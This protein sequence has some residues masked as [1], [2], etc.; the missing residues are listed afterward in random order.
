[1]PLQSPK[2]IAVLV[3]IFIALA[4]FW[5]FY[6]RPQRPLSNIDTGLEIFEKKQD[7]PKT[8]E[9]TS[10]GKT[11]N[12]KIESPAFL[13]NTPIPAKYTCDGENINPRLIIS[14]VPENAKSLVLI[15]DDPDAPGAVWVHWTVWNIKPETTAIAENSA[16]KEAVEGITDFGKS[17]YGGPCPP[18]GTHR[19]FFK[20]YALD[21]TI[22]LEPTAKAKDLEKA[23]QGHILAQAQ[24]VGLY[25]RK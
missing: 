14:G 23:M 6:P 22:E 19:Y 1:M 25:K 18:S 5:H 24:L 13:N 16:P 4:F 9:V 10:G 15:V 12:M 21:I 11:F 3:I 2:V 7:V 20:L 8:K 17:G